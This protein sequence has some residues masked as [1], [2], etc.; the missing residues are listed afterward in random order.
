MAKKAK[1]VI[2]LFRIT[3]GKGFQMSFKNDLTISVQFGCGNYCG[4]RQKR[5]E[6]LSDRT[7]DCKCSTAEIA[8]FPT[9]GDGWLTHKFLPKKRGVDVVGWV[10]PDEV[11]SLIR[12]VQQSKI[13]T[14]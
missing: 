3:S 12:R 13:L 11:A 14:K 10:A 9:S 8:I 6:T 7:G 5:P 4:N 1:K 2:S